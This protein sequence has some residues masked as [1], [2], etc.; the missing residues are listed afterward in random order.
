MKN[1]IYGSLTFILALFVISACNKYGSL[2]DY[3]NGQLVASSYKVKINQPDS[4]ILIGAKATDAISWS[5]I[6]SGYD[7]VITK[8]NTSLI[9]FKKSGKYQVRTNNG[10][11]TAT[12]SITVSDS[13]YYPTEQ[14]T[15]VSLIGDEITFVPHYYKS[16]TSDSAYLSFVVQTHNSYCS[17]GSLRFTDSVVN[18]TYGVHLLNAVQPTQCTLG[19]TPITAIVNFTKNQSVSLANGTFPLSVTLN[20]ITY[21]GSIVA[22]TTT[23]SFNWNYTAGVLISPKQINR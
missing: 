21:T 14:Y 12:A 1:S 9:F 22:T 5:V 11:T 19:T 20:G 8:N 16:K 2:S 17:S 23:I 7:S 4:L 13:I 15:M 6:P 18:N 10:A 3:K